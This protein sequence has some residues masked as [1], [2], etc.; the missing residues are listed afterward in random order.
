MLESS[1]S[2][3][4]HW[5]DVNKEIL[6]VLILFMVPIASEYEKENLTS[7]KNAKSKMEHC[8]LLIVRMK[9]AHVLFPIFE[10]KLQFPTYIPNVL[11]LFC[12]SVLWEKASGRNQGHPFGS[13]S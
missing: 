3:G 5:D 2:P 9:F 8:R 10:I 13:I 4:R 11:R 7:I 6:A 1:S 12:R